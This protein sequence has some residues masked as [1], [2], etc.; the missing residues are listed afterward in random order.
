MK[1]NESFDRSGDPVPT[2]QRGSDA[3]SLRQ[4]KVGR[5]RWCIRSNAKTFSGIHARRRAEQHLEESKAAGRLTVKTAKQRRPLK[6]S[7]QAI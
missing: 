1:T 4:Q 3:R 5:Y 2:L 7:N 6:V